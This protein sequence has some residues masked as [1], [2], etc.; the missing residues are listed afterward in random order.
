[1]LDETSAQQAPPPLVSVL[2]RIFTAINCGAILLDGDKRTIHLSDRAQHHLGEALSTNKGRLSAT[3]RSC[4]T[5]SGRRTR[6]GFLGCCE[7]GRLV[8]HESRRRGMARVADH[9]S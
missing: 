7:A 9:L 2:F 3:D 4:D 6:P 5:D 1:M 8:R